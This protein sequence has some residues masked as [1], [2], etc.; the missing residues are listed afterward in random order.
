MTRSRRKQK[1]K[2][3]SSGRTKRTD[4][5]RLLHGIDEPLPNNLE[6]SL[7]KF[8]SSKKKKKPDSDKQKVTVTVNK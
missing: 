6:P 4:Y 5:Q 2:I 3:R 7:E 1:K 8:R